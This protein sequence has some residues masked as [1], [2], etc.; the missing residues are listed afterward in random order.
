M[1]ITFK[2]VGQGDSIILEWKH[3]DISKIGLIDCSKK[4][5]SNPVL[6]YIDKSGYEEI[7][8]A[9]LSH[10]HS[11]HYSGYLDLFNYCEAN[12]KTIK[13]FYHTTDARGVEYWKYF[14]VGSE[15]SK[16]LE[17]IFNKV[18]QMHRNGTLQ[19]RYL[20]VDTRIELFENA[21]LK[22][23]SPSH[24]ELEKFQR[25]MGFDPSENADQQSKA[26]NYLSTVFKLKI[27]DDYVLFTSDA[28]K[29][30]FR[31]IMEWSKEE[32]VSDQLI[33][34]QMPHHGSIKNHE[35]PFW[36]EITHKLSN[37]AVASAGKHRSYHH[38]NF[39]TLMA[40]HNNGYK[41]YSTTRLNGINE[42]IEEM[43]R[44]GFEL[45]SISSLAEEYDASYDQVFDWADL[46]NESSS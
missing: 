18:I 12:G 3:N 26:A 43:R 45:D 13:R 38:P 14:E 4:G 24:N 7:E 10:P 28:E 6:D 37:P 42:Y 40:F 8:F 36:Q 35:E 5:K 11:D 16:Q 25:I 44:I 9:I 19:I 34:C 33:L 46:I 20:S 22:C 17:K 2:D 30:A 27:N 32:I 41:V 39:D 29:V 1:R 23:L 31:T 15:D 21:F